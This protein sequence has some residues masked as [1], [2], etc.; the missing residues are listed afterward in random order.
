M[1]TRGLVEG[2]AWQTLSLKARGLPFLAISS[3]HVFASRELAVGEAD[4]ICNIAS[5]HVKC[6]VI[7]VHLSRVVGYGFKWNQGNWREIVLSRTVWRRQSSLSGDC[8][9]IGRRALSRPCPKILKLRTEPEALSGL[10]DENCM[11]VHS[12][13]KG[14]F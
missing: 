5:L 11:A 6:K 13:R 8:V 9:S 4:L 2:P 7:R 3:W 1:E 12:M 14:K 10:S